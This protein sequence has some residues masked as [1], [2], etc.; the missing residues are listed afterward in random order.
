MGNLSVFVTF[1]DKSSPPHP[2]AQPNQLCVFLLIPPRLIQSK[3]QTFSVSTCGLNFPVSPIFRLLK[4]SVWAIQKLFP[5]DQTQVINVMWLLHQRQE[6]SNVSRKQSASSLFPA[7]PSPR[8]IADLS[9]GT[10]SLSLD[11]CLSDQNLL[12]HSNTTLSKRWRMVLGVLAG[13]SR[14][15]LWGDCANLSLVN[16]WKYPSVICVSKQEWSSDGWRF[17]RDWSKG[18]KVLEMNQ[19]RMGKK[20]SHRTLILLC[21][22][23]WWKI[24]QFLIG[25][26]VNSQSLA[27]WTPP[28][29]SIWERLALRPNTLKSSLNALCIK[30]SK[31]LTS[32]R[33]GGCWWNS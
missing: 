12:Q 16:L 17:I 1:T 15:L 8:H 3:D 26:H 18:L 30:L 13:W 32:L 24:H 19:F 33:L 4:T 11:Q 6:Q 22:N 10:S 9:Q 29:G 27:E 25:T 2:N 5:L 20:K 21:G 31:N 14:W 23:F 7:P 28:V